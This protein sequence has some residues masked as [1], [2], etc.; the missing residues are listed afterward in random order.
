MLSDERIKEMRRRA[1]WYAKATTT[2]E[3]EKMLAVM[4]LEL[5]AEREQNK[6]REETK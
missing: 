3:E 1:L 5:L 4:I 2:T 6:P